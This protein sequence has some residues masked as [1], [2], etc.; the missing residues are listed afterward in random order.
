MGWWVIPDASSNVVSRDV[1]KNGS[2]WDSL[3]R[4]LVP[5]RHWDTREGPVCYQVDVPN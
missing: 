1:T 2:I 5:Q 4:L 3:K